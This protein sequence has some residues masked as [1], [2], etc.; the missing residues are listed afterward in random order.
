MM[1]GIPWDSGPEAFLYA[2]I[3]EAETRGVARFL[4]AHPAFPLFPPVKWEKPVQRKTT[5]GRQT[6][7]LL[8]GKTYHADHRFRILPGFPVDPVLDLGLIPV[9]GQYGT[10]EFVTDAKPPK[11]RSPEDRE[12]RFAD[13]QK[14][15]WFIH[16]VYVNR[17]DPYALFRASWVPVAA[18]MEAG[19]NRRVMAEVG[20]CCLMADLL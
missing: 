7:S 15:V 1:G 13:D 11:G 17:V 10:H 4:E 9:D 18:R 3:R 14:A 16:G 2:W 5:V 12:R 6:A 8:R 20:R 19:R